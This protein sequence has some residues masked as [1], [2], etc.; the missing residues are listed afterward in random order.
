MQGRVD[1]DP[2]AAFGANGN[3]A[4]VYATEMRS[5][6]A[7]LAVAADGAALQ[8]VAA[9]MRAMVRGALD[10]LPAEYL[11]R[12]IS[13]LSD[14]LAERVL[15]LACEDARLD[16]SQW[17]WIALGSEGRQEQT[18]ASDQDNAIIFADCDNPD[19]QR[20]HLLPLALNVNLMLADCGFPLCRGQIMASN[21]ELCLSLQEWKARFLEW[22]IEGD[23]NALLN[24]TI[25]F[26]FRHLYGA[27]GLAQS[28]RNWLS[29]NA[30][31]NPRFLLQMSENAMG[32][33]PPLGLL[34]SFVVEKG[35]DFPGTI[36]LKLQA[37]TLFVDAARVLAL[38]C[39]SDA[40]NTA[41]RL[42][43]AAQAQLLEAGEVE[44][45]IAAFYSIERL[46]LKIQQ[47]SEA[48]GESMHNHVDP[49]AL[50]PAERKILLN[51]LQQARMLQQRVRHIAPGSSLR[52]Y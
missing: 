6:D 40:S 32:R 49:K 19:A 47:A 29:V 21:P 28:L 17:C 1:F 50:D 30:R 18:F 10:V 9:D 2:A 33:E 13:A 16:H 51:A 31:D 37:A 39:G 24:A 34:R 12:L 14:A 43:Q 42:R 20:E 4:Q 35:G 11:T 3:L 46:R 45:C 41:D 8:R 15:A 38:A 44:S 5:L 27:R 48:R 25:F 22:M 7:A 23:M 36:D 52:M 26:D